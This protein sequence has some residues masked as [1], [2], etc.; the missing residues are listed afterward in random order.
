MKT[1]HTDKLIQFFNYVGN[2]DKFEDIAVIAL[3]TD[4]NGGIT[5][6]TGLLI[7]KFEFELRY[8]LSQIESIENKESHLIFITRKVL[9][10]GHFWFENKTE[11]DILQKFR[12]I[13]PGTTKAFLSS[14][15]AYEKYI[16][17]AHYAYESIGKYIKII[18]KDSRIESYSVFAKA[19]RERDFFT[20]EEITQ[21]N[22]RRFEET[23]AKEV[24]SNNEKIKS[25]G[26]IK[27]LGEQNQFGYLFLELIKNGFI[28]LPVHNGE[29]NFTAFARQCL[30]HF[31]FSGKPSSL[32]KEL[33]E[34]SCSLSDTK[35][36]KFTIP[37]LSDLK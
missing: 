25:E 27:W 34:S 1:D 9:Q 29:P 20:L 35:R 6:G 12:K 30:E 4:Y 19:E 5:Q 26:K 13:M 7:N 31:E 18:C 22:Q 3:M 33:R 11:K 16:I 21:A 36:A 8:N 10:R 24:S 37:N 17:L 28:S 23:L 2:P 15:S 14:C 32:E